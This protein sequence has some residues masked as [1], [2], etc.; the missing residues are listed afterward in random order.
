MQWLFT[1]N[2]AVAEIPRRTA[3]LARSP[4]GESN[5]RECPRTCGRE[6]VSGYK[7]GGRPLVL[8]AAL[9]IS[10]VAISPRHGILQAVRRG[11]GSGGCLLLWGPWKKP[12]GIAA[13]FKRI[14]ELSRK[15]CCTRPHTILRGQG[16]GG[17]A[18]TAIASPYWP[19]FAAEWA[20]VCASAR[21]CL[22]E[23]LP[24]ASHLFGFGVSPADVSVD[25][26]LIDGNFIPSSG[27]SVFTSAIRVA[28]GLQPPGR[29][30]PTLLPEGLGPE[31]H[32]KVALGLVHPVAR[33]IRLKQ[34]L[35]HA[36]ENQHTDPAHLI[37]F[38]AVNVDLFLN[39]SAILLDDNEKIL[40]FVHRDLLG[41]LRSKNVA[42]MREVSFVVRAPDSCA[43]LD[44]VWGLPMAGWARHCPS[45]IQ[46]LS[47][48]PR[49]LE[50][51]LDNLEEHNKSI[52]RSV[53]STGHPEADVLAWSKCSKEF[54]SGGLLGPW[55]DFN[56]IPFLVFRLLQRFVIPEQHGGQ[57]ATVR[58]IDNALLGGQNSFTAT[59]ACH[60]PC[61]L[62]T[63]IAF[64]RLVASWFDEPLSAITSDFKSAYR[65]VTSD[66][67]QANLFVIAMWCCLTRSIVYGA[68][69]SQ[70]FGSGSAPLNFSRYPSWCTWAVSVLFLL[71]ME[72]CV[73]DLLSVERKVTMQS[74]YRV[75][76]AFAEACGWDVP[77]SKSPP[78][79]QFLRTLGAMTDLRN[80]PGAPITLSSAVD[81]VVSTVQD[82]EGVLSSRRLQPAFAGKLYGRMQWASAMTFGRFGR[83]MLRA[84]S[85][86]QH[87]AGR[88]NLNPQIEAACRFWI[89]NL[90]TV[91]PREVPVN[92]ERLPLAISYSDGEGGMAGVGVAL[93]RPA[94]E[95]LAGYIRVPSELRE[96]WLTRGSLAEA[97]DIF[98]V[99]AVGPLLVLW[100]WGHLIKDHLWVHFI[101][102]EGALAALAKGSSSVLSGE[103]IVGL[104]HELAAEHGVVG[105]FDRVDSDSNPIDQLS[106]G[107]LQGPWRLVRVR[108]PPSL[109]SRIREVCL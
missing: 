90:P 65:Q 107:V 81:R 87:E 97:K 7:F 75:W 77:D 70:L 2:D 11:D 39:L 31:E 93:W 94:S 57:E 55:Y 92:P 69:V 37:N 49:P 47:E 26:L 95:T 109:R 91:R 33:P 50:Y 48:P 13:N 25:Q 44:L 23:F 72:Q 66:P 62:D 101:D 84:F 61:D 51:S 38:R 58:C 78:P 73:D 52:L 67:N 32:L 27:T 3:K 98:Q 80:Y 85:R 79:Q 83:A 12:T 30:L 45:L 104:T 71:P 16:P 54:E 63:W 40:K 20:R 8:G 4:I 56:E 60:R 108:F 34:H 100:N 102:N 21:A 17:K 88:S 19:A 28:A 10:N 46:R 82:L 15:C 86:R 18:W 6:T 103:V 14:E 64:I 5:P 106:R 24:V 29:R 42:L 99:E 1:N 74:G 59:T 35:H 96:M 89:E 9:D 105:W 36:I 53:R 76:R 68:A 43:V 22:A 41:V